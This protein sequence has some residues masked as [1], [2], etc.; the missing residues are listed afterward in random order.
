[1]T[2]WQLQDAKARLSELLRNLESEG[3]QEIT[4]HGKPV[5]VVLSFDDYEK[6]SRKEESFVDFMRRS[7]LCGLNLNLKR[8]KSPTRDVDL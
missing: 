5:A 4:V 8:D 6:L 3:P 1:M 7:P 2:I